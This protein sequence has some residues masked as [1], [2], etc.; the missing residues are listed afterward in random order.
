MDEHCLCVQYCLM[1]HMQ[2]TLKPSLQR[3]SEQRCNEHLEGHCLAFACAH[4]ER[5]PN[6]LV[7]KGRRCCCSLMLWSFLCFAGCWIE[8]KTLVTRMVLHQLGAAFQF[9]LLSIGAL[10]Y[11]K[12]YWFHQARRCFETNRCVIFFRSRVRSPEQVG[13]LFPCPVSCPV[14]RFRPK[15]WALCSWSFADGTES[16]QHEAL[17]RHGHAEANGRAWISGQIQ[18][19]AALHSTGD[20]ET[21][22]VWRSFKPAWLKAESSWM[23]ATTCHNISKPIAEN[24]E[25]SA[26]VSPTSKMQ[27]DCK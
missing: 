19:M 4:E 12:L 17:Q 20:L 11:G 13:C 26:R 1:K 22:S 7:F 25:L 3:C 27:S 5:W 21:Q 23:T 18:T 10:E 15:S 14:S 9:P 24:M 16:Q 8:A 2:G 6:G